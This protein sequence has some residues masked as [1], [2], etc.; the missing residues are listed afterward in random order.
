MEDGEAA[1]FVSYD[2]GLVGL[3]L[4]CLNCCVPAF[5]SVM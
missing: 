5:V 1:D 4:T 3:A 2:V